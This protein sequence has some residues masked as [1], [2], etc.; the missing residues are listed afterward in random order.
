MEGVGNDETTLI[1]EV[2]FLTALRPLWLLTKNR[3]SHGPTGPVFW[4]LAL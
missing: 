2:N 3:V 1:A 4:P